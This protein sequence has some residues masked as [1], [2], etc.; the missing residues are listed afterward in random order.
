MTGILENGICERIRFGRRWYRC[1]ASYDAVL[2]VQELFR[3]DALDQR[4]KVNLAVR[5][6]VS[7]RKARLLTSTEQVLLLQQVYD[8]Q[9]RV[10]ARP[11]VSR[12]GNLRVLDFNLDAE[13][14]YA[15]FLQAYG[16]DLIQLRGKLHWKKFFALFEGLP[17]DT[18]IRQI[19]QIRSAQPPKPNRYNQEE[20]RNLMELKSY[21][22]LPVVGG[23][24]E[25]GVNQLF[26]ALER[27][28]GS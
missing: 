6:L 23:G 7:S 2:R 16:L 21:Y 5:E 8:T 9:I 26:A 27:L 20:I 1:H 28:A 19:M 17:D 10:P 3:D 22:A 25:Q 13:Y 14:I 11:Q 12:Q 24:G 15:S 4:D 18:K